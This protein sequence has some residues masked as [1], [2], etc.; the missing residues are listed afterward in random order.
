VLQRWGKVRFQH[1]DVY[2]YTF[3][4]TFGI[5]TYDL[6]PGTYDG[7]PV[8]YDS[9][10]IEQLVIPDAKKGLAFL[11]QDGSI[12]LLRPEFNQA[13]EGVAVFGHLQQRHDRDVT[14][15]ETHLQSLTDTGT[16]QVT[17]L[18]SDTGAERDSIEVAQLVQ[19]TA[20]SKRYDSRI[21]ACNFDIA[22][23]GNF[24][25]SN[26]LIKVMNHGSR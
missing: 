2:S 18:G 6:L 15:L 17:L 7:L 20:R 13:S 19:N 24:M 3:P 25:L 8:S 16:P 22:V 21:T 9:F 10:D 26:M 14:V 11:Q 23:E 4:T 12:Y 5:L 1:V